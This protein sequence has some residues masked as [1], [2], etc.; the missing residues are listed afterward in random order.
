MT[1]EK[2]ENDPEQ[3]ASESFLVA[4]RTML[5]MA[6]TNCLL[7]IIRLNTIINDTSLARHINYLKEKLVGLS[8][9][10][11][12]IYSVYRLLAFEASKY[13]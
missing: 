13:Q 1:T 7:D 8:P 10:L 12:H 2:H 4:Q 6:T 9:R 5:D 3:S 11:P